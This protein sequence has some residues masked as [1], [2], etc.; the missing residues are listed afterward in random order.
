MFHIAILGVILAFIFGHRLVGLL[1]GAF[2]LWML[3]DILRR[4]F[5]SDIL[6]LVLFAAVFCTFPCGAMVYFFLGRPLGTID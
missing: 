6:K 3:I 4:R 5:P 2:W 1:L